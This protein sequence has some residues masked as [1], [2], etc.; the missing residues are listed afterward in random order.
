MQIEEIIKK[1][2]FINGKFKNTKSL[3]EIDTV[4]EEIEPLIEKLLDNTKIFQF[5]LQN[6]LTYIFNKNY[7]K[8]NYRVSSFSKNIANS[9]Y[10]LTEKEKM[11]NA[12]INYMPT[13]NDFEIEFIK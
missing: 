4:L 6:G 1:I 8:N 5:K 11:I 13:S 10:Y 3:I 9:H 12:I 2:K 7:M